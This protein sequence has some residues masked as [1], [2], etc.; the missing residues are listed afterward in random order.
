MNKLSILA[1]L[2]LSFTALGNDLPSVTPGF[3]TLEEAAIDGFKQVA[4]NPSSRHYEWG[5]ML[6][7]M[8]DG[9]YLALPANTNYEGSHVHIS[10]YNLPPGAV[11]AFYHTHP[12]LAEFYAEWFSPADLTDAIF[13]HRPVFMGDFCTGNVHEFK[14]GDKPD[15]EAL[16]GPHSMYTTKGRII[17]QFIDIQKAQ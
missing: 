5:G 16:A 11:I 10:D 15:V 4:A 12:C 13:F 7:H 14:V 9:K 3:P 6:I 2:L 1:G 8:A 17:G